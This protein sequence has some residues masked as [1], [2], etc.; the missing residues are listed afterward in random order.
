MVFTIDTGGTDGPDAG[1]MR[2]SARGVLSD[3]LKKRMAEA[4]FC[5]PNLE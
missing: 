3:R 5:F 4:V 2:T 1:F